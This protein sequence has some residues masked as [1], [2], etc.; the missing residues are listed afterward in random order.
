MQA[1]ANQDAT[2][3]SHSQQERIGRGLWD[4][5]QFYGSVYSNIAEVVYSWIHIGLIQNAIKE[6][7]SKKVGQRT[8]ISC[9]HS[10]PNDRLFRE[11]ARIKP[12]ETKNG[13]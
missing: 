1:A 5:G 11:P 6:S 9:D 4:E 2:E 12:T 3:G 10:R 13:F 7:V 8:F